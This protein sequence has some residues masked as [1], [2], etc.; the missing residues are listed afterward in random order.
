MAEFAATL[1][2]GS[3]QSLKA[4]GRRL[5]D[6]RLRRLL[7][8]EAVAAQAGITRQTLNKVESGTPSVT[9]GSYMRVLEVL[10]L[11]GD[12]DRVANDFDVRQQLGEGE[13]Q[14][15]ER[16]PRQKHKPTSEEA[17]SGLD[18]NTKDSEL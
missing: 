13:W 4:L 2:L 7:S 17:E 10:G 3:S 11:T 8:A 1:T 12:I 15:R 6:A 18:A 14:L 5:R 9:F 16:A